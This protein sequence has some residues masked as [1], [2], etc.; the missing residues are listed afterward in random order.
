MKQYLHTLSKSKR[1][2]KG[3]SKT[4]ELKIQDSTSLLV[5]ELFTA[6]PNELAVLR[7]SKDSV[8][9]THEVNRGDVLLSCIRRS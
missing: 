7:L 3:S 6:S 9:R 1:V 8:S 5:S 2:E 4:C